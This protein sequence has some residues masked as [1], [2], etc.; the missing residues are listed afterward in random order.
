MYI[1][2]KMITTL[3]E[4]PEYSII[5]SLGIVRGI[6]VRAPGVMRG[7]RA[8]LEVFTGGNVAVFTKLCEKT[9]KEAFELLIKHA[10]ELGANAIMGV[11]YDSN[12]IGENATEVLVYGTAII[13]EKNK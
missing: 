8:S 9:R 3:F 1:D 13:V 11:R 5:E 12:E 4:L 6:S 7:M 10:H 2:K